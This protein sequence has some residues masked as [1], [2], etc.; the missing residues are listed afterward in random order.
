MK[1]NI[2]RAFALGLALGLFAVG[3]R[4]DDKKVDLKVGDAAPA[5]EARTDEVKTWSSADHYGKKWVVIYFYP[6]DFTPGCTA[7]AKAFNAAMDKLTEQGVEVIGVSGDSVKTHELF[8]KAMKLNFT[9]LADEAGEVAKKFGVPVGKGATVKARGADKMWSS[10]DRFGKK[11][12]VVYFYPGDFTPGCT[13]QA[14]AFQAAMAKLAEKGVEVVGVS[15]DSLATHALFKKAQKLNFTLLA[16]EEGTTCK[17]FGVPFTAGAKVKS[18]DAEGLPI[19][20]LRAGTA[21]R[22]TFL[23]SPD[24]KVAYKNTKVIPADDAKKITEFIDAAEKK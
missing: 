22:W 23:I 17:L 1:F 18:K 16:D 19:E 21:A 14:K 9:L 15:G 11:W 5:F 4:A 3:A 24:G 13:A 7:Q 20:F 6:G 8:K 12:V 2:L 10:S